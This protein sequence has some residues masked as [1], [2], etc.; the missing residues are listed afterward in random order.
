MDANNLGY[1]PVVRLGL[2]DPDCE[3]SDSTIVGF[4]NY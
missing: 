3:R 2:G 4:F 1:S